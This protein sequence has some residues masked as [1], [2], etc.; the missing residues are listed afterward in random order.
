V[1][2]RVH[3][4]LKAVVAPR[5]LRAAKDVAALDHVIQELVEPGLL[6]HPSPLLQGLAL[7]CL[8]EA[9]RVCRLIDDDDNND[10]AIEKDEEDTG[11]VVETAA[12][13][14]DARRAPTPPPL[15]GEMWLTAGGEMCQR[16]KCA[17]LHSCATAGC[18]LSRAKTLCG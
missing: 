16:I 13:S 17:A 2:Q 15:E 9:L 12:T 8:Q 4:E 3:E 18:A 5:L 7:A 14:R 1:A 10:L 6:H 11:V